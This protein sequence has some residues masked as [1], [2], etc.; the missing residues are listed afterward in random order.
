MPFAPLTAFVHICV[1]TKIVFEKVQKA[2]SG[3]D[4]TPKLES[5]QLRVYSDRVNVLI[6]LFLLAS[7]KLKKLITLYT[8]F[9]TILFI[10]YRLSRKIDICLYEIKHNFFLECFYFNINYVIN[11][12]IVARATFSQ[13]TYGRS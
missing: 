9:K 5:T 2:G 13:D 7:L 3:F 4:E 12:F 1:F 11:Y 6:E 8:N 10:M